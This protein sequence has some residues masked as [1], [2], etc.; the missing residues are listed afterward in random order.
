MYNILFVISIAKAFASAPHAS[1]ARDDCQQ[2]CDSLGDDCIVASHCNASG[3]CEN[4]YWN[5]ETRANASGWLGRPSSR[6]ISVT[7]AEASHRVGRLRGSSEGSASNGSESSKKRDRASMVDCDDSEDAADASGP[8]RPMLRSAVEANLA[9]GSLDPVLVAEVSPTGANELG[10]SLAQ[11]LD[12]SDDSSSDASEHIDEELGAEEW[13]SA[14]EDDQELEDDADDEAAADTGIHE[15][16]GD[17][18][19]IQ[20][21]GEEPIHVNSGPGTVFHEAPRGFLAGFFAALI[22][23][24]TFRGAAHGGGVVTHDIGDAE[25]LIEDAFNELINPLEDNSRWNRLTNGPEVQE[26][27]RRLTDVV[28]SSITPALLRFPLVIEDV[29]E[30][31]GKVELMLA[32]LNPYLD[33]ET[34]MPPSRGERH[35][36]QIKALMKSLPTLARWEAAI[37]TL[38]AVCMNASPSDARLDE[39]AAFAMAQ[40]KLFSAFLNTCG[41]VVKKV[42][43]DGV[44]DLVGGWRATSASV[45]LSEDLQSE[46]DAAG[47]H[48]A[49]HNSVS[50][51]A[52]SHNED[53]SADTTSFELLSAFEPQLASVTKPQHPSIACT[54]CAKMQ[55]A[56]KQRPKNVGAFAQVIMDQ[57]GKEKFW[58]VNIRRPMLKNHVFD[59]IQLLVDVEVGKNEQQSFCA[60]HG[61]TLFR[62]VYDKYIHTVADDRLSLTRGQESAFMVFAYVCQGHLSL[63]A[64]RDKVPDLLYAVYPISAEVPKSSQIEVAQGSQAAFSETVDALSTISKLDLIHDLKVRFTGSDSVG[65]GPRNELIPKALGDAFTLEA[66]LF[67]YSDS[68]E[69]YMKPAQLAGLSE[70]EKSQRMRAYRQIGRMIGLVIRHEIS[71]IVPLTAGC[72]AVLT[73]AGRR[74]EDISSELLVSLFAEEDP[75]RARNMIKILTSPADHTAL[76]GMPFPSPSVEELTESNAQAYVNAW[77]LDVTVLANREVMEVIHE[78]IYDVLPYPQ[79][80]WLDVEELRMLVQPTSDIDR[81]ELRRTT[82]Y[83]APQTMISHYMRLNGGSATTTT[84]SIIFDGSAEEANDNTMTTSHAGILTESDMTNALLDA[85]VLTQVEP[86]DL[87]RV[88]GLHTGAASAGA[89]MEF[90]DEPPPG[91]MPPV[92][93]FIW[94]WEIIDEFSEEEMR[95]LL[96][97]VS[98]SRLQPVHGFGGTDGDREWLQVSMDTSISRNGLPMSQVCFSQLRLPRYKDKATMKQQFLM[99]FANA[100]TLEEV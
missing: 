14:N 8:R 60:L 61:E 25:I 6:D 96:Y 85:G 77:A 35:L 84:S 7:C 94:F 53:G 67:V 27:L 97:F 43:P 39:I 82:T 98:G 45:D 69:N 99:A 23:T 73:S 58:D 70:W 3:I 57:L 34:F 66:G 41:R 12:S 28:R 76:L 62:F 56:G 18:L 29:S 31:T 65:E 46:E 95:Q 32:Q 47:S 80:A 16:R 40:F 83:S 11:A 26:I 92:P 33:V 93:E 68:R 79:L 89:A 2:F 15:V 10:S 21:N 36:E 37:S 90:S 81:A 9:T 49:G 22:N 13:E 88:L 75:E 38:S 1:T 17:E 4:L 44:M 87:H 42:I 91:V 51:D 48:V 59:L 74:L 24:F 71:V 86:E 72:L 54:V 55:A 30:A 100:N 19:V 64:R 50:E 63:G 52:E 5:N 78:G 20:D